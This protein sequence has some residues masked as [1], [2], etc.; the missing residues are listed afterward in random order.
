[1][2]ISIKDIGEL[3]EMKEFAP[4]RARKIA[5]HILNL[6]HSLYSLSNKRAKDYVKIKS[7]SASEQILTLIFSDFL[8][9][10]HSVF[11]SLKK[12]NDRENLK[13][14]LND[15]TNLRKEISQKTNELIARPSEMIYTKYWFDVDKLISQPINSLILPSLI[16]SWQESK[17]KIN[18]NYFSCNENLF[19]EV[20]HR[21]VLSLIG[22]FPI[23]QIF[24]API[25]TV[26]MSPT[27][28]AELRNQMLGMF[29][30]LKTSEKNKEEL[31][32]SIPSELIKD[33]NVENE[34]IIEEDSE[35]IVEDEG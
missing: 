15:L 5:K 27:S 22:Q 10:F 26:G 33:S 18:A 23:V 4:G 14:L 32:K 13:K 3:V 1:M 21:E 16:L 29:E 2:E 6:N 30:E 35:E 8:S 17:E 28:P 11:D 12:D 19:C 24:K 31:G 20:F 9:F 7:I 25:K 34:E